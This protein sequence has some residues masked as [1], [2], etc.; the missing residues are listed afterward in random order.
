MSTDDTAAA[1]AT[2]AAPRRVTAVLAAATVVVVT[3]VLLGVRLLTAALGGAGLVLACA[4]AAVTLGVVWHGLER[5]AG[6]SER[7]ERP[8]PYSVLATIT[9]YTGMTQ[10]EVPDLARLTETIGRG[11]GAQVC[12]LTVQRPG[13]R[14][15]TQVWRSPDGRTDDVVEV[16]VPI[17]YHG[18]RIG[19]LGVDRPT[20]ARRGSGRS[21]RLVDDLAAALGAVLA[22]G[23][24]SIDLERQLRAARAHAERI[25]Q[26]RRAAVARWTMNDGRSRG[27]CTTAS[28]ATW[29]RCGS[30]SPSWNSRSTSG[31]WSR[32]AVGCPAC[33]ARSTA[34]EN[35]LAERLLR[36][37]RPWSCANRDSSARSRPT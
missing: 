24:S 7:D 21:D 9:A 4:S 16:D 29:S 18:E 3:A 30:R 37:W 35:A 19:A 12:R 31:S 1:G 20:F 5:L 22:I 15:R 23:R 11:L 34:T 17:E 33:W 13:L 8:T 10:D 32:P 36:E 25:A 28:R 2:G 6:R 26:G 27:T 14:D